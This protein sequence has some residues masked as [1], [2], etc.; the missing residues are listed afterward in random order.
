MYRQIV[1][2]LAVSLVLAPSAS[3][4]VVRPGEKSVNPLVRFMGIE[5][6]Q[7]HVF[8][9]QIQREQ[10]N[11]PDKPSPKLIEVKD[12]TPFNLNAG[13]RLESM[14]LLAIE[15]KE[16]DKR[17]KD[18]PSLKWLTEEADGVM[19]AYPIMPSTIG[20]IDDV[21]VPLTS[22]RVTLQ[23]GRLQV[24]GPDIEKVQKKSAWGNF[25]LMAAAGIF[26]ALSLATLGIWFVRRRWL[27]AKTPTPPNVDSAS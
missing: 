25:M 14:Y 5:E 9:L 20:L 4:D 11:E 2:A 19:C 26:I 24:E 13:F 7:E 21:A 23:N 3:A 6:H 27:G 1:S 17:A 12:S 16:F 18:D 10:R 22:Y 8:Y 15:R